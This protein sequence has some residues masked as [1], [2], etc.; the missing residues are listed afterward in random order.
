M[1]SL[2][3]QLNIANEKKQDITL[4]CDQA[5]KI[6]RQIHQAQVTL[7]SEIYKARLIMMRLKVIVAESLNFRKRT[8]GGRRKGQNP[9]DL[10]G[11]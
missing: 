1:E 5:C 3:N 7:T 11:S 10:V 8:D 2:E 6:R 9:V 4:F